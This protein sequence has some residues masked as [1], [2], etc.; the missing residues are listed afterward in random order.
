MRFARRL[1]LVR[2]RLGSVDRMILIFLDEVAIEGA[3]ARFR[4]SV[5]DNYR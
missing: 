5:Y 3:F 1:P 4:M 2:Y